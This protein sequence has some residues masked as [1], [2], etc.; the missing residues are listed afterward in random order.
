MESIYC[1]C[2]GD[3]DVGKRITNNEKT[4]NEIN[5]AHINTEID[6]LKDNMLEMMFLV[7]TQLIKSQK[8]LME[9]DE[10]LAHDVVLNEKRVDAFELRIDR[11]CE[12]ILALFN[13][14]A[15]DLRFVIACLKMNS[16]LERLGDH[17]NSIAKFILEFGAPIEDEYFKK[18]SVEAMF[19]T[20]VKM[21]TDIFNA[22]IKEDTELAR[23]VFARDKELNKINKEASTLT[24]ELIEEDLN[25]IDKYIYLFTIIRK[26]ERVGDLTKNVAEDLI[27]F[28]EAKV[29]KHQKEKN[30]NDENKPYWNS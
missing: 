28:I 16:D 12:D 29:L 10:E 8:A 23:K 19:S 24:A 1:Y 17:A 26:L 22:F 18:L 11:D 9:F 4:I 5:M 14:V 25:D 15:I 30:N 20:S 7:K 13:P 2:L 27:F 6:Q 21:L 3:F